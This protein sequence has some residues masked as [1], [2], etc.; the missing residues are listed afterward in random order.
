MNTP[1]NI[2][3]TLPFPKNLISNLENISPRLDITVHEATK[4]DEIPDDLWKKTEVLYTN[5]VLP[6]AEQAPE[7]RW[8]QFHWAGIDH[9]LDDPIL[10]KPDL[11]ST[12]LSGASASQVAEYIMMMLLALGHHLPMLFDHQKRHEWSG[13][14][15]EVFRPQELRQS[16]VGIVGYGS[17]GR[18][19]ARVLHPFG[20]IVLATKRDAMHPA[21]RGY[22]PEGMGDQEGNF[23][24]RIY[25]TEA[26]NSMLKE[27]D[28]V[29]ITL[30]KT[31][32]T[33]NLISTEALEVMK[34]TSYLIDISRGGIIDHSALIP[35]LKEKKIAGAALDV[36]PEEP[37]PE[38]N[39][40]W[41]LP[42]VIVTPHISGIT[43]YYDERAVEMFSANLE[44][45][46][47]NQPLFN[48]IDINLG[49]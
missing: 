27:C 6:T 41:E 15:W 20:T 38:D 39:P 3:V 12:S 5:Y 47:A 31:G 45:Y 13:E 1:I 43:P 16:T 10:R 2:L 35:A 11:V 32:E 7:L 18:Q 25:P 22:I 17:I 37:L 34:P 49:Y 26:L 21:D 46:L 30:P 8:I 4:P 44:R 36:F 29:V 23:V 40:L 33:E 14:R 24:H 42:N 9:I 28:F 48:Q 19:L